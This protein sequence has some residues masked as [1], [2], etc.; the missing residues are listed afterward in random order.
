MV[1]FDNYG[2]VINHSSLGALQMVRESAIDCLTVYGIDYSDMSFVITG[3]Y[4]GTQACG[5]IQR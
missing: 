1:D 4:A 5:K 3:V 2:G